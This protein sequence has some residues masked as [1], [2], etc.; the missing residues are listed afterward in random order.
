MATVLHLLKGED[1]SGLALA[2]I[3]GQRA[4]GDTVTVALL[5]HAPAPKLPDGVRVH[6][7]PADLTYEGLLELVFAADHVIT[8]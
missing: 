1:A 8:W 7:V 4:A 3:E 2:T 5:H 6:R